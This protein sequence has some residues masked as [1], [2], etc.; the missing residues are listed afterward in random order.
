MIQEKE[1]RDKTKRDHREKTNQESTRKKKESKK[2]ATKSHSSKKDS[3]ESDKLLAQDLAALTVDD[4]DHAF[5]DILQESVEF[6]EV[7][8]KRTVAQ[9]KKFHDSPAGSSSRAE[10][11]EPRESRANTSGSSDSNNTS[12]DIS[13]N[14]TASTSPLAPISSSSQPA[15]VGTGTTFTAL[16]VPVPEGKSDDESKKQAHGGS[17]V[18][19]GNTAKSKDHEPREK[20]GKQ[21]DKHKKDKGGSNVEPTTNKKGTKSNR[22]RDKGKNRSNNASSNEIPELL[23]M[24][25]QGSPFQNREQSSQPFDFLNPHQHQENQGNHMTTDILDMTAELDK[26]DMTQKFASFVPGV[27]LTGSDDHNNN[28]S[29]SNSGETSRLGALIGLGGTVPVTFD[30]PTS[31]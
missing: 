18:K 4:H 11:K 27:G 24:N 26:K 8:S 23:P 21:N 29:D 28:S 13:N 15:W 20:K 14:K 9:E 1:E 6:K 25:K 12:N 10:R 19:K 30:S 22:E 5:G 16:G 2:V 31:W 17:D 7:K 3:S